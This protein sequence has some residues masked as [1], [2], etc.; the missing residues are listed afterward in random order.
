MHFH[1]FIFL[2]SLHSECTRQRGKPTLFLRTPRNNDRGWII[3]NAFERR[4]VRVRAQRLGATANRPCQKLRERI[5]WIWRR[6]MERG[7][8]NFQSFHSDEYWFLVS[9]DD[10]KRPRWRISCR[11][12]CLAESTRNRTEATH[13]HPN[14]F[15]SLLR[16]LCCCR[17][18]H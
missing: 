12:K 16:K 6:K 15:N 5:N 11:N 14:S 17:C 7:Q 10:K 8:F 9:R 2:V 1:I 13:T 4:R 18:R 3:S